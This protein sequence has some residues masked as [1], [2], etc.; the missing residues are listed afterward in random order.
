[1]NVLVAHNFYQQAGGEDA[2]FTDEVKLLRAHGHAVETFTVHNDAVDGMG[3]FALARKTI[4]NRD[5][6]DALRAAVKKHAADVV[7]FHNTF[8][9]VSPAGYAAA[10]DEGAA[11]EMSRWFPAS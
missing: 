4:W 9:L 6:Y 2:V 7:H 11:V 5:S 10:H 1:M 3:K 8:P